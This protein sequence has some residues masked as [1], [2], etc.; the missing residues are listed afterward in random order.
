VAGWRCRTGIARPLNITGRT[1]IDRAGTIIA[2]RLDAGIVLIGITVRAGINDLVAVP[3]CGCL[4]GCGTQTLSRIMFLK[5]GLLDNI[6]NR[7]IRKY[8]SP[9][10]L[11]RNPHLSCTP[12]KCPNRYNFVWGLPF[13]SWYNRHCIGSDPDRRCP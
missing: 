9:G 12:Q 10:S 6:Y 4:A 8:I 13:G 3:V 7:R 1:G 11:Y 5:N 2:Y